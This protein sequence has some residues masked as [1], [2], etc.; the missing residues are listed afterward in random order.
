MSKFTK[1]IH[2]TNGYKIE[3]FV[4][5]WKKSI[6]DSHDFSEKDAASAFI[7]FSFRAIK[8][9]EWADETIKLFDRVATGLNLRDTRFT[10]DHE[11][12]Q[13]A[14]GD[15]FINCRTGKKYYCSEWEEIGGRNEAWIITLG[16]INDP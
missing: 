16:R 4:L 8:A 15:S 11:I 5:N 14:L 13:P 6:V 10:E 7:S 3:A 2:I 1:E 12:H 9:H